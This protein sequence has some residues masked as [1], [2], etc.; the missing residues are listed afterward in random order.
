MKKWKYIRDVTM[1]IACAI[2]AIFS[3]NK[4]GDVDNSLVVF[5]IPVAV[6]IFSG[7]FSIRL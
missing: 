2:T 1:W 3:I 7:S 4:T 6:T 5:L